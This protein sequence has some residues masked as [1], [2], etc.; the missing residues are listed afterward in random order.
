MRADRLRAVLALVGFLLIG[1]PAFGVAQEA[2]ADSTPHPGAVLKVYLLTAGPGDIVWERFSH[3]AIWIQNEETGWGRS[4]NWGIFDFDQVNF[5]PRLIRGTML[6]M[7]ASFDPGVS[8]DS[9][10][11]ANRDVWVQELA[12]TPTQKADLLAFVEWNALPENRDYR[13]DYYRDNC[14][15]RV[16]DVLDRVLEGRI[17]AVA[18]ADT[19]THSYRWHTRRL[20]RNDPATYA[21]IQFVLGASADRP[22]TGWEEMFLPIPLMR[23]LRDVELPDGEGG[24]KPLV[25][26]EMQLVESTRPPVPTSP[27][28]ASPWFLLVGLLWGGGI[29]F[30]SR[31]GHGLGRL[32]RFGLAVL[33]GGWGLAAT[34]GGV[35]LLGAWLFTD[36]VFWYRN[37][38]LLQVN[39]L[40]LAVSVAFLP[41]LFGGSFPRWGRDMATALGVVAGVGLL[42]GLFPGFGQENWEILA[43]TVPVNAALAVGTI[44]LVNGIG[45][46]EEA[47]DSGAGDGTDQG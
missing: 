2:P 17:R 16:R 41:F 36:H 46:S 38:N 1:G 19:T 24:M 30:L 6:Y 25:V 28:F 4:Y 37:I 12:L 34:A 15:T 8:L 11:S 40:F 32:G 35:L 33:G 39:P 22:L 3:N 20:L 13:Y 23:R 44:W 42:M 14:S 10:A 21:G 18:E 5:I 29:L 31:K 9:Y 27:P 47:A 43:L 7:M 26:R 45:E